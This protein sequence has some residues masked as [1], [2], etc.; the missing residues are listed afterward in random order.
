M[1]FVIVQ[2]GS[3]PAELRPRLGDFPHWFQR[4]LGLADADVTI[5]DVQAGQHLPPP[6]RV[7]A[8]VVTGSA[9]MVTQRLEWSERTAQWLADAVR[10]DVPLLGVCYG[11][12]LLAHALGGRVADNPR[13]REIGTVRIDCLAAAAA[14]PLLGTAGGFVA[15]A[16]HLQTVVDL[17]VNATVLARSSHDDCQAVRYSKRA[18]GLQFHPEFSVAAMR[19]YLRLRADALRDEGLDAARIGAAVQHSPRARALLRRFLKN[20]GKNQ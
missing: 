17:P 9:A 16:T 14:D 6:Q 18:W 19:G 5:V 12:Q 15:H 2:T 11:H 13:G 7:S 8:A 20:A 10:R 4:G 1:S 3:A